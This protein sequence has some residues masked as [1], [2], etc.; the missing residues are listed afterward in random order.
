MERCTFSEKVITTYLI[1]NEVC[2]HH[3]FCLSHYLFMKRFILQY[4]KVRI[5][6]F[7]WCIRIINFQL[8]LFC[9]RIE[10]INFIKESHFILFC[11]LNFFLICDDFRFI[12][13]FRTNKFSCCLSLKIEHIECWSL[14]YVLWFF[15][16]TLFISFSS[17]M[18]FINKWN[19]V[20]KTCK[21]SLLGYI[22]TFLF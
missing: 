5:I 13:L 20:P 4:L 12:Y 15:L 3:Q 10:L 21:P 2:R 22:F 11:G 9:K 18:F 14:V 17:W 7:Y 8:F 19:L 1:Y 16:R 6:M